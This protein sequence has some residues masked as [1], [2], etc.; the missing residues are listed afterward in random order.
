MRRAKLHKIIND[1]L[2][3]I[4]S[5]SYS[6][7]RG[8][9]AACLVAAKLNPD[10]EVLLSSFSCLSVPTA[11]LAAGAKPVYCDIDPQTLNV[12][13]ATVMAAVSHKTKVIVVQHTL[14]SIAPVEEI[15]RRV[16]AQG[17]LV[18][19]DCALALGS[20]IN[21]LDVGCC[22]DAAIFSMELSKTLSVGWGG[23]LVVNNKKLAIDL[24]EQYKST[25]DLPWLKSL[26]MSLQTAASGLGYM[27]S[28]YWFGKYAIAVGFK[29][30]LFMKSTSDAEN[31]G[32]VSEYFICKLPG[33]QAA[34]A[35]H[36]WARLDKV[37][38]R[39]ADNGAKIKG[40]V[41]NIGYFPLGLVNQTTLSVSPRISIL[42]SDRCA[43]IEWFLLRGIELGVWF[44]GPMSPLP[45]VAVY[46][47]NRE[48]Y[49]N[50]SFIADHIVNIPCHSRVT[51][52]DL[53]WIEANII[54][55]VK[56]H[57]SNPVS[58]LRYI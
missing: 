7:G 15:K 11:V 17:I 29:T 28:C 45:D 10:D 43:M 14:G 55:Y 38:E 9:L 37:A 48:D 23:V 40:V 44:D 35:A 34:L 13:V 46:N 53:Q 1:R 27:P 51:H 20:K 41:K 5:F 50:A 21:G 25:R 32:Q 49:P 33:Q 36:Q 16:R 58:I 56:L 24:A 12:T 4:E 52:S 31:E 22:G 30:G 3:C 42:V 19:E 6:S 54:D 39:C 8:A 26:Q 18:I 57:P 2:N 47:Y